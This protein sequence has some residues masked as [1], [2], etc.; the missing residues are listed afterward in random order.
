LT[1]NQDGITKNFII[2][3]DALQ[4]D[5]PK[6]MF[7]FAPWDY[8]ATFGRNWDASVV[9]PSAWLSNH[10][11]DRLMGDRA[12]QERLARRWKELREGPFSAKTIQSMIDANVRALGDAARRN[13]ARWRP[14]AG[15]YPDRLSLDQDVAQMKSWVEERIRWLDAE[16][17]RRTAQAP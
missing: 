8:D 2:G 16:I 14:A 10:L 3:R 5:L 7:F 4:E 11:F 13:A 15:H 9:A 12:F 1:S 17:Q 6:P